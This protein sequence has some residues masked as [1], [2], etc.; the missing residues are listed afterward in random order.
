MDLIHTTL[1]TPDAIR[2]MVTLINEDIR[3][4]AEQRGLDLDRAR[5]QVRKV[6]A[7]PPRWPVSDATMSRAV[8]AYR[9]LLWPA[10]KQRESVRIL[11]RA[12]PKRGCYRQA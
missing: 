8:L 3:L 11:A 2:R 10:P 4:R 5:A 7:S 6:R 12:E 1:L 9:R